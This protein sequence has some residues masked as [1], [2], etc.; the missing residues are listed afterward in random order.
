MGVAFLAVISVY[1]AVVVSGPAVVLQA[2]IKVFA[3]AAWASVW[4]LAAVWVDLRVVVA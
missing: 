4:H 3:G 1:S 2:L